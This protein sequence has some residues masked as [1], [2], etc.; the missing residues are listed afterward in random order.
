[1]AND[2]PITI[3]PNPHRVRVRFAGHTV[4]D[5]QAP[6][7]GP[8]Y[9]TM[10]WE[11]QEVVRGEHDLPLPADLA[12]GTY[13]MSLTLLPDTN[14]PAGVAYLGTVKVEPPGK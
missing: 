8:A 6:L 14:T 13:R 5:L 12:P 2:H 3:S 9:S 7:V 11:A 4:A 1:M 10:L